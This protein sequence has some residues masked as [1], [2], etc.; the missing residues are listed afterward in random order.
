M[1][2]PWEGLIP[3]G[4]IVGTFCVAGIGLRAVRVYGNNGHQPRYSLDQ[5]DR[6]MLSRD[7]RLT[8]VW[9]EQTANA[10]APLGFELNNPWQCEPRYNL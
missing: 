5:W 10:A 6:Q 9:R 4:I 3:Y 1:G 8:G 7:M 2:V